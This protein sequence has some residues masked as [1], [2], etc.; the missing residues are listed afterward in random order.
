VLTELFWIPTPFPGQLAIASRP[1]G[2]DWLDDEM[3]GWRKVGIDLIVS[4]LTPD[5]VAELDL[6]G[7]A[8]A[9]LANGI[10]FRALP[11]VDR[12]VPGSP[13]EFFDLV[14][15]IT[16][17]LSASRR[18]AI[19]CR[20][21]IGRAG[22]VAVG[23]LIGAGIDPDTAI[24]RVS[25]ARGRPVPETQAQRRWLDEFASQLSVGSEMAKDY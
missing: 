10:D 16:R 2:G 5:E 24:A 23:V 18:V 1:R 21:G 19:H 17:E 22:M 25:T 12:D 8:K 13:M 20:Q 9:C 6:E 14:G 7:E 3:A 4:L 15:E 11:I